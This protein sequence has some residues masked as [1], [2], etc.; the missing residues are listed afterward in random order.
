[1]CCVI[2]GSQT[3]LC[4]PAS[5]VSGAFYLCALPVLLLFLTLT[6]HFS[7]SLLVTRGLSLISGESLLDQ[8]YCSLIEYIHIYTH[9]S[10]YRQK[11]TQKNPECFSL[12]MVITY[13]I[14][15]FQAWI[16]L[17]Y[18]YFFRIALDFSDNRIPKLII[19]FFTEK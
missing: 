17:D 18:P 3:L 1:M 9:C 15:K 19:N 8:V 14:F 10:I 12:F 13:R 4:A 11:K 7:L 6:F 16:S 5:Q 2:S